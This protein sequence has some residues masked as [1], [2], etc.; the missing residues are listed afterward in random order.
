MIEN[1][2]SL[3]PGECWQF[4]LQ[5]PDRSLV[6]QRRQYW[7]PHFGTRSGPAP[8]RE[9]A[10]ERLRPVLLEATALRMVSDVPVGVFLSGGID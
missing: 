10:I 2:I 3:L 5:E 9:E 7:R 1:V 4:D 8:R 6:P